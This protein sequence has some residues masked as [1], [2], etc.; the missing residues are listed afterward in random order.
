MRNIVSRLDDIADRLEKAGMLREAYQVDVMSNTI[1]AAAESPLE[2]TEVATPGFMPQ[3]KQVAKRPPVAPT[4]PGAV[5]GPKAGDIIMDNRESFETQINS[6]DSA[7]TAVGN[8][9]GTMSRDATRAYPQRAAGIAD[10]AQKS[11]QRLEI[12]SQQVSETIKGELKNFLIAAGG[13][14]EAS[15]FSIDHLRLASKGVDKP[16]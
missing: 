5:V 2:Q 12:L 7:L 9:I 3:H 16:A 6:V 13:I 14:E 11:K 8:L 4:R 15:R 10:T 1:E